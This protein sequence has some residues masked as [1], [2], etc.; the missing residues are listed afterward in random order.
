MDLGLGSLNNIFFQQ[1][2]KLA[3]G[4]NYNA[5]ALMKILSLGQLNKTFFSTGKIIVQEI[6]LY[7]C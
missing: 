4:S 5:C 6:E 7:A 3:K 1:A 2:Y